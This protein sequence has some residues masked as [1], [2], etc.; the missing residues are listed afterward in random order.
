MK[1]HRRDTH[2]LEGWREYPGKKMLDLI[3]EGGL[4]AKGGESTPMKRPRVHIRI[5]H[6][7]V[8]RGTIQWGR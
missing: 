7:P 3:T 5:V 4:V 2:S 8:N 6:R 1:A